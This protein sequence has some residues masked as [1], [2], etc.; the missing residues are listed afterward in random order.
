MGVMQRIE[1]PKD[2]IHA[3]HSKDYF[4][5]VMKGKKYASWEVFLKALYGLEMDDDEQQ[6]FAE[7]SERTG[8]AGGF[9]ETYVI[10]GRRSGKSFTAS[11][12][13]VYEGLFGG[14]E[15]ALSPG[16]N[17]F[18]FVIATDRAQAKIILQYVRGILEV[19]FPDMIERDLAWDI[20]LKNRIVISIKSCT[21][22]GSRGYSTA[23]V[24]CEEMA[25]W[26]SEESS[27]N[28]AAEVL[29]SVIPSLMDGAKLIGLST[30]YAKFGVLYNTF[31]EHYGKSDSDILV[32]KSDTLTLNP[33][34]KQSLIDRFM[35]R[36]KAVA[37]SEY[38]AEWREDVTNFLSESQVDSA[39]LK[40]IEMQPFM[41]EHKHRYKAFCDPSGG[42]SDSM[43][44]AIAHA[45]EGF[46]VLD[47]L[48][49][50]RAPFNPTEVVKTFVDVLRRYGIHEIEGDRYAGEWVASSYKKRN[51][52][53]IPSKLDKSQIY[54]EA[55]ALISMHRVMLL[56]NKRLK[57]QLLSLER[58]VKSGGRDTVDHPQSKGMHD[59]VCNAALGA[60]VGVFSKEIATRATEDEIR[61]RMPSVQSAGIYRKQLAAQAQKLAA[62]REMDELM[63]ADGCNKIVKKRPYL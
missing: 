25:F 37:R 44:L 59:D 2:I 46:C 52:S 63:L 16:E 30:P 33:T 54:L 32:F 34:Y 55:Q 21:F 17:A 23:A 10:A 11:L 18:I 47:F 24:L 45:D 61:S 56:D 8:R 12:I 35:K 39:T 26:R 29:D 42:K 36:D 31:K 43:T 57:Q 51:I 3:L 22:R 48:M 49:E 62:A 27:A 5:P 9:T 53:Y 20:Y 7:C 1:K 4:A 38:F 6:L 41:I 60:V 15:N 58:R 19:C 50:I 14:F 28:P 40:G 13:A